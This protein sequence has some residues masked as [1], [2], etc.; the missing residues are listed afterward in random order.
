M[1]ITQQIVKI[2]QE[3]AAAR[4]QR[5]PTLQK[6]LSDIQ[7]QIIEKQTELDA[8]SNALKRAREFPVLLRSETICPYCWIDFGRKAGLRAVGHGP[9]DDPDDDI[10]R[11]NSCNASFA[12]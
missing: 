12:G 3:R 5:I 11:C 10:F 4:N 2:A 6:E 7:A 9:N 1:P 8:A